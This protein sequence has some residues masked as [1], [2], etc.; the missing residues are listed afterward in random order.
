MKIALVVP[1]GVDRSG[2]YRV[3]PA[4]LSLIERLSVQHEIHVFAL[5]QEDRPDSWNL[6]GAR[7]HNIG[8][9]YTRVRAVRAICAEHRSS[10]FQA[11]QSIWSGSPGL[12]A[13][14]AARVL[15]IPVFVHV[16]GGELVALPQVPYGGRLTWKGRAREAVV[17]R[18]ATQVTAASAAMI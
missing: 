1:G 2:E 12:V 6:A 9:G 13:V 3:I 17:L 16:A 10:P 11:V 4:L 18:A 8:M 15:G 14:S 7:I 5:A